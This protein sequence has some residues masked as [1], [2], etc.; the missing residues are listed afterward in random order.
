LIELRQD[1]QGVR[2]S[3]KGISVGKEKFKF[4]NELTSLDDKLRIADKVHLKYLELGQ[5]KIQ[6]LQQLLL[7]VG[8]EAEFILAKAA[9]TAKGKTGQLTCA[10]MPTLDN[11]KA[12]NIYNEFAG[13]GMKDG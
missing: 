8:S 4:K 13:T 3:A 6:I 11:I 12:H 10:Q 7:E 1:P 5:E 9:K 2:R